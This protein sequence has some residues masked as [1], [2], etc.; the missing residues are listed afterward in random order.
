[1]TE[2]RPR[3]PEPS[4]P[5]PAADLGVHGLL[6]EIFPDIDPAVVARSMGLDV[7]AGDDLD[8]ADGEEEK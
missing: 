5:H 7:D 8:S 1:M 2:N 3:D 4:D 6:R